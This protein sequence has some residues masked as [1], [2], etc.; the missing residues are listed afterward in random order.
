MMGLLRLLLTALIVAAAIGAVGWKYRD[1]ILNPW[2]RDGQVRADVIAIAPRVTGPIVELPIADNQF[3]AAGDVL[4]RI[5]PRTFTAELEQAQA[6]YDQTLDQLAALGRQVDAARAMVAQAGSAIEQAEATVRSAKASLNQAEAQLERMRAL[7]ERDDVSEARY[8]AQLRT[9][10]V[11]VAAKEQAD[12]ALL[13]AEGARLQA[14][15]DLAAAIANRGAEGED[16]ARLRSA[17][18]TLDGARLSLEFTEQ[19]APVDGFV[20]NLNLQLGSQATANQPA[21]ALVDAASFWVDAYFRESM[22]ADIQ[23]GSQAYVTLMSHPDTLLEG[24]VESV[25]WGIARQDGSTAADL[26]PQVQPTFPWIRLAQRIPVR[27]RLNGLPEGVELRVG[28]TASI[29]VRKTASDDQ[30]SR[31]PGFLQ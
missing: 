12:A 24:V 5:D 1:Y 3:V 13:Q 19:R 30:P 10:A 29:L 15:A 27:V 25:A 7:F 4:F 8:E 16:N 9:Y 31:V 11:D 6:G 21:L 22:I 17:S 14:E 26:L 2:T 28:T 23:P 18:A 20:T